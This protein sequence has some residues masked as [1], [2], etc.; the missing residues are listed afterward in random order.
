MTQYVEHRVAGQP[1]IVSEEETNV[2][3]EQIMY[4]WSQKFKVCVRVCYNYIMCT[5]YCMCFPQ[6]CLVIMEPEYVSLPS[7]K[8]CVENFF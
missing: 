2:L 6:F 1:M 8:S 3:M 4:I 7:F 5:Q